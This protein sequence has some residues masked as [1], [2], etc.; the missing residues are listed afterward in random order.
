M[1]AV[2]TMLAI[3]LGLLLHGLLAAAMVAAMVAA[4][5]PIVPLSPVMSS[6]LT[7]VSSPMVA[8]AMA[9]L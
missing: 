3:V 5:A 1:A 8:V 2:V 6:M 9:V 7:G 4:P